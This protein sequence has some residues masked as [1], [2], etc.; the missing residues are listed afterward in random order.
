MIKGTEEKLTFFASLTERIFLDEHQVFSDIERP[1]QIY[2]F[3][4]ED[5]AVILRSKYFYLVFESRQ[6]F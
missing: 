2:F 4:P 1:K 3:I 6:P 5:P